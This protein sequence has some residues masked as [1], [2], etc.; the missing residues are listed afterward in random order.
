MKVSQQCH[1]SQG[2]LSR[3][4]GAMKLLHCIEQPILKIHQA[5]KSI[6]GAIGIGKVKGDFKSGGFV[7]DPQEL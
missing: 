7:W 6:T 5:V 3:V 2:L 4:E 1:G